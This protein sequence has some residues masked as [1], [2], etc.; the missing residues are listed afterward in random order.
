MCVKR[1]QNL[2][3]GIA[4]DCSILYVKMQVNFVKTDDNFVTAAF[5]K[6]EKVKRIV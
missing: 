4:V 1:L 5:A 2:V 6:G 3:L